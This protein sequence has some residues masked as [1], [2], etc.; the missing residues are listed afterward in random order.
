MVHHSLANDMQVLGNASVGKNS[1]NDRLEVVET[2]RDRLSEEVKVSKMEKEKLAKT[3]LEKEVARKSLTRSVLNSESNVNR[4][5]TEESFLV[6]SNKTLVSCST[7]TTTS[8]GQIT[9]K[10]LRLSL[11]V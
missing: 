7:Q 8:C 6:R 10:S 2:D 5:E 3:L 1:Q 4:L 9:D 11:P